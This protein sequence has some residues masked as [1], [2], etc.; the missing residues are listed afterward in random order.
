MEYRIKPMLIS[1][2]KNYNVLFDE[3]MAMPL[4]QIID[5]IEG[6]ENVFNGKWQSNSFCG[7]H[8][9]V[10][11]YDKERARISNF[12]ELIGEEPTIEIYNMLTAYRDKLQDYQNVRNIQ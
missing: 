11:D 5:V 9:A 7:Q 6:M 12:E 4:S 1:N 10:V 3:I 2:S 8:M